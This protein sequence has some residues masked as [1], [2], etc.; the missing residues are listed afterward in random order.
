M[1]YKYT[2]NATASLRSSRVP[3]KKHVL[4]VYPVPARD[5]RNILMGKFASPKVSQNSMSNFGTTFGKE[6]VSQI[7]DYLLHYFFI[8]NKN[9]NTVG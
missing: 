2:N 1:I 7:I 5:L 3:E 8:E 9:V 4:L 6:I